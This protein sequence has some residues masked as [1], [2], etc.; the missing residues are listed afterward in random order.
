MWKRFRRTPSSLRL[1]MVQFCIGIAGICVGLF[2]IIPVHEEFGNLWTMIWAIIAGMFYA[3]YVRVK[4]E[5]RT[6]P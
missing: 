3:R 1:P 6:K 5:S 2:C 4:K